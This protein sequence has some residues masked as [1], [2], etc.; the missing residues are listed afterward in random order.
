LLESSLF[1]GVPAATVDRLLP[2]VSF[3]VLADHAVL[4]RQGEPGEALWVLL[5]GTVALLTGPDSSP[6]LVGVLHQGAVFGEVALL[7]SGPRAVTAVAASTVHVAEVDRETVLRWVTDVPAI[8]LRLLSLLAGRLRRTYDVPRLPGAGVD[9]R[10]AGLLVELADRHGS[11]GRRG[12]HVDHQLSQE[13]L[14]QLIGT[15]RESV[16]KVLAQFVDRGWLITDR[17]R[18][19]IRDLAA[20]RRRAGAEQPVTAAPPPPC[21]GAAVTVVAHRAGQGGGAERWAGPATE[22]S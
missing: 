15:T 22:A 16:N 13:Q 14:A 4:F 12:L 7:D 21:P 11:Q 20:L 10:L 6:R 19:V 5:H 1:D 9:I 17:R 8:G 18:L 3:R 2:S